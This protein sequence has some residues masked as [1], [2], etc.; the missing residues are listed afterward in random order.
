MG[1]GVLGLNVLGCRSGSDGRFGVT[2]ILV[3]SDIPKL[4]SSTD[5]HN[6]KTICFIA[7]ITCLWST[8][9]RVSCGLACLCS[10]KLTY[11]YVR[12]SAVNC[13]VHCWAVNPI[14]CRSVAKNCASNVSK[15]GPMHSPRAV[16]SVMADLIV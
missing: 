11:L 13:A 7:S 14:V 16:E 3:Q 4:V 10:Y 5:L 12:H 9:G 8:L 2:V 15:R 6:V 1:L